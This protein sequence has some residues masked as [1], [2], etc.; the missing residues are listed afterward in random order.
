M[1]DTP[2]RPSVG[3]IGTGVMGGGMAMNLLRAGYPLTVYN[4]TRQKAEPLLKAGAVWAETPGRLA[5]QVDVVITMV[6]YP[7][8]VQEL[9]LGTDGILANA[10]PGTLVIDMTTS[11]PSLAVRIAAEA[12]QRSIDALDAPVS[13]GDVGARDGTLS[14]MAGGKKEAYDRAL[15]LFEAMGKT[16]VYQG[17]PGAGQHAKMC[18][19]IA[20]AANIMGVCE[21]LGY[22][23]H[24]GLDPETM[25]R[26]VGGGAAASWQLAAYAPR[27]LKGDYKPGFYVKHFIKDMRIAL[28]EAHAMGMETPALALAES[29]YEKLS[30]QGMDNDGTQALFRL[31][32]P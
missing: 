5:A 27:I 26:S 3:F 4:R 23:E 16:Q 14:V 31:Y 21:A 15:P 12:A 17:G 25:L 28:E 2:L 22:A 32:E 29:L 30:A 20:I 11:K 6:G 9:Y 13:G 18:N 1:A 24:A 19:Q 10:R 8:D 7:R